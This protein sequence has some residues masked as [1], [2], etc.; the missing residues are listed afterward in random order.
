MAPP[1]NFTLVMPTVTLTPPVGKLP[2]AAPES[3]GLFRMLGATSRDGLTFTPTGIV[4]DQAN[5]PDLVTDRNGTLYLYYT[6]GV[7]NGV[8][9]GMA[10][11]VSTD[12]HTWTHYPVHIAGQVATPTDP[13]VVVLPD[14]T[15]R[16]FY[17]APNGASPGVHWADGKDG[18]TFSYGG[19][20]FAP[21]GG[22]MDPNT[23]KQG[24]TWHMLTLDGRSEP[25]LHATSQ[26][27]RT[28][29]SAPPVR[30]DGRDIVSNA[31]HVDGGIRM[32]AFTK[33]AIFSYLA[34]DGLRFTK[35]RGARIAQGAQG[36]GAY[37]KDAAVARL[38]DGTWFAA[39][40]TPIP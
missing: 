26:D 4:A 22:A 17:T 9:D 8:R 2:G 18:R 20:A 28:F 11:A 24:D 19:L 14:G 5:V 27:G 16:L 6:A 29:T 1:L 10:V 3:P 21:S 37:L 36:E 25:L 31:V 32:F 35:E 30:F 7:V 12:A 13:D 23:W 40:V 15:F 39:Y 38:R 33:G 34:T